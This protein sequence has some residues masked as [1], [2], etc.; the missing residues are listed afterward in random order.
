MSYVKNKGSR[1]FMK[2]TRQSWI[3]N[4]ATAAKKGSSKRFSSN[5][6][7]DRI[8]VYDNE[9]TKRRLTISINNFTLNQMKQNVCR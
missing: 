6:R 1:Y 2:A 8:V 9:K 5:I 3:R 4:S 7:V